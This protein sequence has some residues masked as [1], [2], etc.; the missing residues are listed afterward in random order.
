MKASEVEKMRAHSINMRE[1]EETSVKECSIERDIFVQGG[2]KVATVDEGEIKVYQKVYDKI[3]LGK[4][5]IEIFSY[6]LY[7]VGNNLKWMIEFM[8]LSYKIPSN[9][10]ICLSSTNDIVFLYLFSTIY[11]CGEHNKITIEK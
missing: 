7:S 3:F 6:V 10:K 8:P 1:V 4:I 5:S 11:S 2:I 9:I